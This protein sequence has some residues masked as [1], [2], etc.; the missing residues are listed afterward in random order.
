M[1]SKQKI[2]IRDLENLMHETRKESEKDIL[3]ADLDG[4]KTGLEANHIG[5]RKANNQARKMIEDR[6][7]KDLF[8]LK[9]EPD[10][11]DS[12]SSSADANLRKR[13]VDKQQL[14][15]KA[16]SATE[17]L[18]AI[19]RMMANQVQLSEQ[20]LNTLVSSSATVTETHE[21]FKMMGN[22]M[23]HSKK[24]LSKY[25]RREITDRVLIIFALAF[26]FASCFYVVMKRLF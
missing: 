25:G 23:V 2:S 18:L 12:N 7:K 15:S 13:V 4:Y 10:A 21:E 22:L 16:S 5:L 19:S 8:N 24:L 20:S 1:L 17:E 6:A 9:A 3:N 14:T 26:F 11:D